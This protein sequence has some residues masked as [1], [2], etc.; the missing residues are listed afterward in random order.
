M[1]AP[2][3]GAELSFL[4]KMKAQGGAMDRALWFSEQAACHGV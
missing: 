2:V 1:T 3:E 4:G